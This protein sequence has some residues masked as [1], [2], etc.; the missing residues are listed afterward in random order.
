MRYELLKLCDERLR[1]KGVIK[2]KMSEPCSICSVW[3]EYL[4]YYTETSVCSEEC[5]EEWNKRLFQMCRATKNK[6]IGS[7]INWRIN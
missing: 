4:D 6:L 7:E 5:M 3:T 1:E 2:G